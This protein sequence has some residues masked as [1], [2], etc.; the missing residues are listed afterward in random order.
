VLV[1][2]I[3][4]HCKRGVFR[5]AAIEIKPLSEFPRTASMTRYAT[6][7]DDQSENELVS[8]ALILWGETRAMA[9]RSLSSRAIWN[10]AV[11]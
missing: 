5:S 2:L 4:I 1:E 8:L 9:L 10:A 7:I 3:N 6:A 11:S